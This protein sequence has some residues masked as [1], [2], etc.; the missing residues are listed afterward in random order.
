MSKVTKMENIKHMGIAEMQQMVREEKNNVQVERIVKL[1]SVKLSFTPREF[2]NFVQSINIFNNISQDD[3]FFAV[4]REIIGQETDIDDIKDH[5]INPIINSIQKIKIN[6]RSNTGTSIT[7]F[8]IKK[9]NSTENS[10]LL[11]DKV[12]D[13]ID[14]TL[15]YDQYKYSC[16]SDVRS[17]INAYCKTHG[18]QPDE[19]LRGISP[20]TLE[21][22]EII[23]KGDKSIAITSAK[24]ILKWI[25]KS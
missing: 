18:Q 4:V 6:K 17:M 16:I 11:Y 15:K 14:N 9:M 5:L 24:E 3:R 13:C 7:S 2:D 8:F 10:K 12:K 23:P 21:N 22:L 19:F 1:S 20:N 25:P